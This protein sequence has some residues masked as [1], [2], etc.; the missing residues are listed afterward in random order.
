MDGAREPGRVAKRG[1]GAEGKKASP[2]IELNVRPF[3]APSSIVF[4]HVA[5]PSSSGEARQCPA[6]A[7]L[8]PCLVGRSQSR[9]LMIARKISNGSFLKLTAEGF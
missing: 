8:L 5:A 9:L 7:R 4:G 3:P 6:L 1:F 2:A